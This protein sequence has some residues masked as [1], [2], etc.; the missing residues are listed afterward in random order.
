M[1]SSNSSGR[2]IAE[3]QAAADRGLASLALR[4]LSLGVRLREQDKMVVG[5]IRECRENLEGPESR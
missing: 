2:P 1:K 3:P 5:P 4:P